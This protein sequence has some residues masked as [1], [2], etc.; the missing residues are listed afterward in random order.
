[1]N[2]RHIEETDLEDLAEIYSFVSVTENT[3]QVPYL[4]SSTTKKFF[5]GENDYTL[6]YEIDDKVVGHVTL[7]LS[8]KPREKHS[9]TIAIAVHPCSQGNGVGSGLLT[10][11]INQ[12]DNWLNLSRLELEVYP[13]NLV[14]IGLYNKLGFKVEG[15][16]ENSNF[17]NGKFV[18]VVMMARLK[19]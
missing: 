12:A 6:V 8:T 13:D 4:S 7:I 1:M 10:E 16:K 14:G 18:N 9:A 11:A 2:I 19:S 17:K 15:E 3:S 5:D